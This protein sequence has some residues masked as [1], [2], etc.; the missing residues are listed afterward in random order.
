MIPK[1]SLS[2]SSTL[3]L[4]DN[5]R[6]LSNI[7]HGTYNEFSGKRDFSDSE[8]TIKQKVCNKHTFVIFF[9][10]DRQS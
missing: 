5:Y 3:V 2:N 7:M 4:K 10:S 1:V 9:W 8:S 6:S